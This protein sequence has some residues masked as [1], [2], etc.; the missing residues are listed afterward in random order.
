[1]SLAIT[2]PFFLPRCYSARRSVVIVS[3]KYWVCV[4]ADVV[5]SCVHTLLFFPRSYSPNMPATVTKCIA[6]ARLK[7]VCVLVGVVCSFVNE[8]ELCFKCFYPSKSFGVG[9]WSCSCGC[10]PLKP[11]FFF[12]FFRSWQRGWSVGVTASFL[13]MW[14]MAS[15]VVAVDVDL[16]WPMR[17]RFSYKKHD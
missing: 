8:S 11:Y 16:V 13:F 17:N 7:W 4:L 12:M 2:S 15:T 14:P 9:W 1:M 5:C 3:G 10:G 6:T